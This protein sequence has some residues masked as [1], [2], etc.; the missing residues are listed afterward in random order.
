MNPIISAIASNYTTSEIINYI[1]RIFPGFA[2]K[3]SSAVSAGYSSE[4]IIKYLKNLRKEDF[5]R[6]AKRGDKK[7]NYQIREGDGKPLTSLQKAHKLWY[8]T[9]EEFVPEQKSSSI[10]PTM[11]KV[12][13]GAT[14]VGS[15]LYAL[16]QAKPDL[17]QGVLQR[18]LPS[19][20]AGLVGPIAHQQQPASNAPPTQ[21]MAPSQAQPMQAQAA[22]SPAADEK[23]KGL[24]ESFMSTPMGQLVRNVSSQFSDV[25]TVAGI[26]RHFFD[27]DV[28]KFE[29]FSGIPLEDVLGYVLEQSGK[30]D[31]TVEQEENAF[32]AQAS[33][34]ME[35]S[36]AVSEIPS[37]L[38]LPSKGATPA[39]E[40]I[41]ESKKADITSLKVGDTFTTRKGEEATVTKL[42]DKTFEYKTPKET[43][44]GPLASLKHELEQGQ[45]YE[46]QGEKKAEKIEKS[47][48]VSAPQ[49]VGE[50]LAN[51][52]G[53]ALVQV[54]AKKYQVDEDELE[55]EPAE[56]KRAQIVIKPED[57]PENLRSAA[58][59]FVSVPKSRRDIDIMYGPSGNFYRYYRKDGKPVPEDVIEKLR[60]GQTMPISSGDTYMG[61]FDASFAD[62]RGT[63]AYHALKAKAQSKEAVEKG[64][65]RK[66]K[67]VQEE[68][69]PSKEY[70]V[71][72]LESPFIHGFIDN[73]LKVLTERSRDYQKAKKAKK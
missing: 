28:K 23:T 53:K 56:I 16:N 52:N 67:H 61:A 45:K 39:I 26:V 36:A 55:L 27:K 63:V 42:N 2:G 58:L 5:G 59:G 54:G 46:D 1:S 44:S 21:G 38:N 20:L 18:A 7:V 8:G 50:V 70:W 68:D 13:L 34:E 35:R 37:E 73:F 64:V 4:E 29:K 57:I 9:E 32:A 69:D 72:E 47:S 30:N 6:V 71:E 11:G 10:L 49:G 51:R 48:I 31:P 65:T 22:P 15:G 24:L 41:A 25:P 62:S 60:E 12:A 3:I 40:E 14:A 43:R 17:V 66:G 33:P 19:N